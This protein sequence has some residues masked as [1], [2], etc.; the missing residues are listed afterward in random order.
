MKLGQATYIDDIRSVWGNE[1]KNFTPWLAENLDA[2]GAELGIDMEL[3]TT[4]YDVGSFS[5][6]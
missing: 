4:E 3:I 5:T 1:A 2:L 6:G